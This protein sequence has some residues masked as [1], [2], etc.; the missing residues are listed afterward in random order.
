MTNATTIPPHS[1]GDIY[2][3]DCHLAIHMAASPK[4]YIDIVPVL[5]ARFATTQT[6]WVM[7]ERSPNPYGIFGASAPNGTATV[8]FKTISNG[9]Y[10]GLLSAI[11]FGIRARVE[12]L[13]NV[14][15]FQWEHGS[16][17]NSNGLLREFC[18]KKRNLALMPQ[19]ELTHNLF[20]NY[21]PTNCLD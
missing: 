15:N 10:W 9:L 5:I 16:N 18:P 8:S 4:S 2:K 19:E 6:A 12:K 11:V 21:R 7:L 14:V 20:L 1:N 17:E 13:E 3:N